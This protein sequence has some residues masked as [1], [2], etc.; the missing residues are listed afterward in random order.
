VLSAIGVTPV[1]PGAVLPGG[2]YHTPVFMIM[3]TL[4]PLIAVPRA[5][6]PVGNLAT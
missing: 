6:V 1:A 3:Y 2:M 5:C 4:L